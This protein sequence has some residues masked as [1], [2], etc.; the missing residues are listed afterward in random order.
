M[1]SVASQIPLLRRGGVR[2]YDGEGFLKNIVNFIDP[3]PAFAGMTKNYARRDK[4]TKKL[5]HTH[6]PAAPY[7]SQGG[8]L[9][10]GGKFPSVAGAF[11]PPAGR[12][13]R[14]RGRGGYNPAGVKEK[15]SATQWIP[16]FAEM[17]VIVMAIILSLRFLSGLNLL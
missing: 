14:D 16:A 13:G 6:L 15:L 17:A 5:C 2:Q 11:R 12:G 9:K 3:I 8:E 10:T 7:S 1:R 4:E